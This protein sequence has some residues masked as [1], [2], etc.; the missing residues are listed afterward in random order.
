MVVFRV[1]LQVLMELTSE[2]WLLPMEIE[3]LAGVA[4]E[5]RMEMWGIEG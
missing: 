4:A 2:H 1:G 5:V 3:L